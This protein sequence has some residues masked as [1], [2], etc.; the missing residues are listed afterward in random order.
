MKLT[1]IYVLKGTIRLESGLHIGA[2]NEEIHIGGVDNPVI[3]DPKTN[4]PYIPGSSL[5]GK[6]R[7]LLEWKYGLISNDG[8][9]Y[10]YDDK[11][12]Q[13]KLLAQ[14]FGNGKSSNEETAKSLGPTRI[15]FRDCFINNKTKELLKIMNL[16]EYKT[17]VS[18]DRKTGKAGGSGPRSME[19]VPAGSEFDFNLN[20]M[21]FDKDNV[22]KIKNMIDEGVKLLELSALGGMSSRGYGKIN[23]IDKTWQKGDN[24]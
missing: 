11:N 23:F 20:L 19:R 8:G 24:I 5:K 14:I 2:G 22:D 4:L 16:S 10:I 7:T 9:P 3:K 1:D 6:I 12:E 15:L 21:I 13:G 17:E 18:I